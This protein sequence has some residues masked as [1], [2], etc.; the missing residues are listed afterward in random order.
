MRGLALFP[1]SSHPAVVEGSQGL[2]TS[3]FENVPGLDLSWLP[4][5]RRKPRDWQW[6]DLGARA[7]RRTCPLQLYQHQGRHETPEVSAKAV[8][9]SKLFPTSDRA[10]DHTNGL[11]SNA[12][13]SEGAFVVSSLKEPT[14]GYSKLWYFSFHEPGQYSLRPMSRW[15][16]PD[17]G[18]CWTTICTRLGLGHYQRRRSNSNASL[19]SRSQRSAETLVNYQV[20]EW[21]ISESR[22]AGKVSNYQ[23]ITRQQEVGT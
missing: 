4:R 22:T 8:S 10:L 14:C 23:K 15:V 9:L 21:K 2:P 11:G 16:C 1:Q 13:F 6:G 20:L 12:T 3:H 18:I 5:L 19:G 17:V 7:W